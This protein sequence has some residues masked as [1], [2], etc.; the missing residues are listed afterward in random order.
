MRRGFDVF[1]G[2][3]CLL[4]TSSRFMFRRDDAHS[5]SDLQFGIEFSAP[6]GILKAMTVFLYGRAKS[7]H[8]TPVDQPLQDR[9]HRP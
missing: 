7:L 4:V 1:L 8:T 2:P 5:S 3:P 9:G 6:N